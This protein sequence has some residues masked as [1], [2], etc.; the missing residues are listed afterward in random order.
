MSKASAS[1]LSRGEV[2]DVADQ[3]SST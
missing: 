1:F 3:P 2:I